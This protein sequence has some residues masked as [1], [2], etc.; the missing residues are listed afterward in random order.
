R[1]HPA[2]ARRFGC[3]RARTE[4]ATARPRSR[5]QAPAARTRRRRL[6]APA[7]HARKRAGAWRHRAEPRADR[8]RHSR[9]G[10]RSDAAARNAFAR[11]LPPPRRCPA[12]KPPMTVQ[13]ARP[14][15]A[16]AAR[17][18]SKNFTIQTASPTSLKE[19]IVRGFVTHRETTTYRALDN[20]SFELAEGRSLAIA[21]S[22]GSG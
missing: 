11:G 3:R 10:T 16:V 9:G 1:I 20:I 8:S 18:L 15:V 22:N 21:G 5:A 17:E 13:P 7:T 14:G 12:R 19:I 6:H 4:R 2:S